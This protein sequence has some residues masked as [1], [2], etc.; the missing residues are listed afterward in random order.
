MSVITTLRKGIRE[1]LRYLPGKKAVNIPVLYGELLKDRVA[2]ITGSSSGI[3]YA[4]AE[5]F[6]RNGAYVIVTGRNKEKLESAYQKLNEQFSGKV[7][8]C[9]LDITNVAAL[10]DYFKCALRM[11]DNRQIDILVNNAGVLSKGHFG[12]ADEKDYDRVMNTDLK[13]TYFFTEIVARYMKENKIQGNILNISSSSSIRPATT[14]YHFAKWSM[15]G[16]TK[17]LAK[18]LALSGIVV[19]ALA[20]GPTATSL[21]SKDDNINRPA[22]PIGRYATPEEIANLAVV[23]TSDMSRMVVG[24]TCFATGGCGLLTYDDWN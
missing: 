6:L 7:C 10:N 15:R 5:A 4:I 17:G 2:L 16:F 14:A 13:G 20:P 3:G 18:E 24:D 11:I 9:E 21:I 22:S 23:L 1:I 19:N 8:R 12:S